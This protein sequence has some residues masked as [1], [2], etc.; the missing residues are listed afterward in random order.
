MKVKK[1]KKNHLLFFSSHVGVILSGIVV[2][3]RHVELRN[4]SYCAKVLARLTA[5]DIVGC[6]EID[7]RVSTVVDNW[8]LTDSEIEIMWIEK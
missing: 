3:R 1:Y 6:P 7:N 2:I 4:K 5:G 8:C